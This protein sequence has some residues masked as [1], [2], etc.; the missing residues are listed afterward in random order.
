MPNL[1]GDSRMNPRSKRVLSSDPIMM[2]LMMGMT[3]KRNGALSESESPCPSPE[4]VEDTRPDNTL[5][6]GRY[7]IR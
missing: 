4:A 3:Y 1:T 2:N 5:K 6:L 7:L